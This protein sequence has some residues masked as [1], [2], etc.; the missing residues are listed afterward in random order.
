[1]ETS[2]KDLLNKNKVIRNKSVI[3]RIIVFLSIIAFTFIYYPNNSWE[4]LMG[5]DLTAVSNYVEEGLWGVLFNPINAQMGKVRPVSTI[6]LYLSYLLCGLDFSKYYLLNRL[7]LAGGAFL[8]AH[9][10]YRLGVN[11]IGAFLVSILLI[12]TP[13]S[14]YAVWQMIGVCETLSLVLC[15]AFLFLV[16][17]ISEGSERQNIRKNVLLCFAVF[18]V[19]IFNAERFMYLIVLFVFAMAINRAIA[20]KEKVIY[21]IIMSTP[22]I[23]RTIFI[24]LSGGTSLNTGRGEVDSL[25]GDMTAYAIRGAVNM[26]GFSIGDQWHGGFDFFSLPTYILIIASCFLLTSIGIFFWAL[27]NYIKERNKSALTILIIFLMSYSSLFSYA[28]VGETHGEDRFLWISYVSVCLGMILYFSKTIQSKKCLYGVLALN[29]F[30]VIMNGYYVKNKVHVHYRYSQEMAQTCFENVST[31]VEEKPVANICC[32][33]PGDYNWVFCG[34]IFFRYYIDKNVNVYYY[35]TWDELDIN[36]LA[37]NTIIVYPD[38]NHPIPYGTEA[39]WIEDFQP[40]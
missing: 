29:F 10:S 11:K 21:T 24:N 23:A 12:S 30:L 33:K 20:L 35:N 26:Y 31:L 38:E 4:V 28:L 25:I 40:N 9:I 6:L 13:F 39:C 3:W 34:N 1:M 27:S 16:I 18:T 15:I 37:G 19:I 36:L 17:K 22:I 14:S 7:M 5:D 32:I 2:E 8:I